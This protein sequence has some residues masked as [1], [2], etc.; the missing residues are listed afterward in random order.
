[1][2]LLTLTSDIGL[3]DYIPAAIKGQLYQI[4]KGFDQIDISHQIPPFNFHQAAYLCKSALPHFPSGTFHLLLVNVFDKKNKYFLLA[5]HQ[6][7]YFCCPD[8]GLLSM[9]LEGKPQELVKVAFPIQQEKN[10]INVI[11]MFGALVMAIHQGSPLKNLGTPAEDMVIQ[12]NL[13]PLVRENFIEGQI[14]YID[15]FENVIINITRE[16][17]EFH[18]NGRKFKICF[19]RDEFIDQISETYAD[20]LE[21]H[22]LAT[23]NTAGYLEISINKGNAAGLLGL[24]GLDHQQVNQGNYLQ[25][26]LFYQTIQIFFE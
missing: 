17:F 26:R 5:Q 9:I 25:K 10:I 1:M 7:Q 11:K 21:G 4:C 14:I 20:V 13:T 15:N 12:N 24:Q 3:Q 16:Q 23:F 18:R 22:K 2:P 19:R 8:N 6:N